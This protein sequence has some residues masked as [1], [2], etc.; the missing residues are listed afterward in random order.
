MKSNTKNIHKFNPMSFSKTKVTSKILSLAILANI[1]LLG[2][3]NVYY[4]DFGYSYT[5]AANEQ[6]DNTNFDKKMQRM[7]KQ[8]FPTVKIKVVAN[9]FDV[10]VVGEVD[11]QSTKDKIVKYIKSQHNV[12]Q[13]WD[14]TT[15]SSLPKL[16]Y[17]SSIVSDV[18]DRLA[19]EKDLQPN[20]IVVVA[21][22]GVVYLMGTNIG[23]WTHLKTAIDGIYTIEGVTKVVNL[24][25][26]GPL[27][28]SSIE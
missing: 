7:V 5:N 11:S 25:Q 28:Y 2:C 18:E 19:R 22:D 8:H 1:T 17:D 21:V 14:Y 27:D 15:I 26:R 3:S 20:A 24:I 23:N 16:N 12:K 6:Y 10:L 4:T 13:V 9:Y